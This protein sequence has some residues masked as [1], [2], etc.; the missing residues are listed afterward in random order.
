MTHTEQAADRAATYY[1][2]GFNCA[3]CMVLMANDLI[4]ADLV[5]GAPRV[6]T[7]L[8]RGMGAHKETCGALSG[9]ILVLSCL[10][11]R[12]TPDKEP[13][14]KTRQAANKYRKLF[15]DALGYT[16]C[17]D[18]HKLAA[19]KA[20]AKQRC[21]RITTTAAGLLMQVIGEEEAAPSKPTS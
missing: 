6:A 2:Q 20:D 7:A 3:E 10:Y 5:P 18:F 14:R 16:N 19:D 8:G 11:G 9:G 15:L 4:A 1:D 21:R 13:Y 12:E 17:G